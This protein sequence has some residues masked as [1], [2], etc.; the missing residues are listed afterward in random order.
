MRGQERSTSGT[1]R[2][3]F[4]VNLPHE[5]SGDPHPVPDHEHQVR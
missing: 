5:G 4:L 2:A 1:L 3:L